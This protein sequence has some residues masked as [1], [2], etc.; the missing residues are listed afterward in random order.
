MATAKK[1]AAA[2]K[3][4]APK[5]EPAVCTCCGQ[6]S[7]ESYHR[8]IVGRIGICA[9]CRRIRDDIGERIFVETFA[10]D[11]GAD[12]VACAVLALQWGTAFV[13]AAQGRKIEAPESVLD[14]PAPPPRSQYPW[15][16]EEPQD[17]DDGADEVPS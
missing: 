2:P 17:A 8:E 5:S 3:P 13:R 1:Q 6:A 10:Q 16:D 14:T 11:S 9:Q 15:E 4:A 12:P 7:A